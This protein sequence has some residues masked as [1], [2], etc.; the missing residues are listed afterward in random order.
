M[1]PAWEPPA[2]SSAGWP[3]MVYIHG[4]GYMMDSAVKYHY[5]KVAQ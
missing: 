2:D 4:G 5:A 3:V 1:A